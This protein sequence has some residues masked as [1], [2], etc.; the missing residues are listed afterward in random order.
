MKS[1]AAFFARLRLRFIWSWN[2]VRDA[3]VEQHSFRSWVWANAV[4]AALALALPL[5]GGER[6]LIL[7]LGVLVLAAEAFNTAIEYT[8][9]YISTER[10]PLAGRAKDAGSAGVFLSAIAA[11]VAWLA[12]LTRLWLG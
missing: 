10:H 6:A 1:I 12:V 9:D 8:V 5:T 7:A 3:W 11:G 2:G 4:S